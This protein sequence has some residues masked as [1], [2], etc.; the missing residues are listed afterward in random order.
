MEATET[1]QGKVIGN[2]G[3]L[4]LRQATEA[5]VAEIRRVG[6][7]GAVFITPETIPLLSRLHLGNVGATLEIPKDAKIINGQHIFSQD[8]FKHQSEPLH[9]VINGQLIITPELAKEELEQGLGSLAING[10]ILCP[11]SLAGVIQ[12]KL[13]HISGQMRI[14]KGQ[15]R[16]V[17]GK[18]TLDE[19][20]LQALADG[21]EL[22]VTGNLKV[23][24]LLP[25]DL[26]A[27][28]VQQLQ[29]IGKIICREE[30]SQALL[31]RLDNRVGFPEITIVPSGFEWVEN[32][33]TLD[34]NLLAALPARKLYCMQ[35]VQI[36][37]D[38]TP[39]ALDQ[40]L[41]RLIVKDVLICP[42]GLKSV[43]AQKCNLLET[44]AIFY[45]GELWLIE[46][47]LSMP[48]SR[49][50]YLAGKATLVVRG[51]LTVAPEVEPKVLADRLD[52]VHNFGE[53]ICTPE[54]MAAFQARLGINEGEFID[55]SGSGDGEEGIGNIGYLK[56]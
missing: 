36:G 31:T 38:L 3:V 30:S 44:Q 16:L 55:S 46:N 5:S 28:K 27:R 56:L 11:E 40:A 1:K 9:M 50:D 32:S 7:V 24:R 15:P 51:E 4:D 39:E 2:V 52:K 8:S 13:R 34:A 45:Q 33:L 42:L 22:L 19:P 29:V 26:L 48:P 12:A 6:N 17:V 53:I 18:L 43:L 47:E 25:E 20:Y 35:L 37:E 49:F 10:Q 54:Q 21:S 23:P 41:E 14:Y